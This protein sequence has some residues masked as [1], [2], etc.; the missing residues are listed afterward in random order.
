MEFNQI[1]CLKLK[2]KPS[3]FLSLPR[4]PLFWI[5]I[6]FHI[7]WYKLF[8]II[9]GIISE[10]WKRFARHHNALQLLA[11]IKTACA[12]PQMMSIG[13]CAW[14]QLQDRHLIFVMRPSNRTYRVSTPKDIMT[15]KESLFTF[16]LGLLK[17]YGVFQAI[18]VQ[19]IL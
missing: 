13:L 11:D 17:Y 4:A 8:V 12:E 5:S 7:F 15:L 18:C 2:K 14:N 6:L 1:L 16:H 19:R 9:T 10:Y 3:F